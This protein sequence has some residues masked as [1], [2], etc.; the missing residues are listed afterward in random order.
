M[1]LPEA[2]EAGIDL[3]QIR[4]KNFDTRRLM[5]L[6]ECAIAHAQGTPSQVVI[7]DRLDV[8]WGLGAAGVHLGNHSMPARRVRA[9]TPKSFM[10]GVSC[11]SLEEAR[12]AELAEADYILL[13]PVFETPAKLVYG[14]PLGLDKFHEIAARVK[15]P[16][17]ALGGITLGRVKSCL[18]AG[19][20]GIAA[21][22]LFQEAPSLSQRVAELRA[23][24]PA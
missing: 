5:R 14:P 20:A 6:A 4:A 7:N 21:I 17:L 16:I 23:Q 24:F 8:A 19:A 2:V 3:I 11:H 10:V 9:I 18:E 12:A 22:R 1:I 15:T 13:G